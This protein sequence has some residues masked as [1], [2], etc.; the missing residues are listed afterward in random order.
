ML[1]IFLLIYVA[2][3][4]PFNVCFNAADAVLG[5]SDWIDIMVDFLFTIDIVI[6]F[7]S[8]YEDPITQLPVVNF[9]LISYNYLTGWFAL[10]LLAVLPVQVV[11]S[12]VAPG[13]G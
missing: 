10:D 12:M 1:M 6:N 4:V 13:N 2:T 8:S 5:T 11:E 7:I 9:K 3:Y